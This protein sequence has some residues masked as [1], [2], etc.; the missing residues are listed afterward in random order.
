MHSVTD[1]DR[2]RGALWGVFVG[3]ALAMP[4]RW[5]YDVAALQR[6]FGVIRHYRRSSGATVRPACRSAA[7]GNVARARNSSAAAASSGRAK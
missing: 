6:D 2:I 3:D 4:V 1:P 5:Y 7:E